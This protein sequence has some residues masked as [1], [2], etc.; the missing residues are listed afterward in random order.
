M[1]NT[2]RIFSNTV[3]SVKNPSIIVALIH[4]AQRGWC[5]QFAEEGYDVVQVFYPSSSLADLSV[6]LDATG[7]HVKTSGKLWA[8]VTYGLLVDDNLSVSRLVEVAGIANLRAC[9]HYSPLLVTPFAL[10][11][12]DTEGRYIQ[13]LV[14]LASSQETVH[15]ALQEIMTSDLL[16]APRTSADYALLTVHAY[17]K[18]EVSPPFP[19]LG[20]APA[21]VVAGEK[22]TVEPSILSATSL[23][24]SRTLDLLR[25]QLGPH[26]PLENLWEMHTYYEFVE[27]DAP[28]TMTTMVKVPYVNHVATLTGGVGYEH[29]ARFYKYHFTS[30]SVTPPDT[31]LI[32]V[33]RTVGSNRIIDEMIFKLS[34]I[35]CTHT[36]EIDYFL[37][38]IKPTGKP[39]EIAIVGVVAFRG[40]KLTFDYWDQASVLVQLG[41]IDPI[42]VPAVAGVETARKVLDPFGVP[43]NGLMERWKESEGLSID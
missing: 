8:L 32:T 29:L 21:T 13:T 6:A 4:D 39:L 34:V 40:D 10:L 17:P 2:Y 25:R 28:K 11:V 12:P 33:S 43:S 37:P 15:A 24:Y 23:A 1:P 16:P 38:G 35:L 36:T 27:R 31:E 22:S 9:V 5:Q 18:V 30:A 41:I 26:F 3:E 42:K 14:H 7:E 20:K 19:Y